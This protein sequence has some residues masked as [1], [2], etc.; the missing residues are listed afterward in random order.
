MLE[1]VVMSLANGRDSTKDRNGDRECG[2]YPEREDDRVVERMI[3]EETV[4][5]VDEPTK[6]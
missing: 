6:A 4:N 2:G 5:G 1:D 3:G